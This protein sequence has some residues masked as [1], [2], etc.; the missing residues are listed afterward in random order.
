MALVTA[1][2]ILFEHI[3]ITETFLKKNASLGFSPL[4][5]YS[6]K[7]LIMVYFQGGWE[8]NGEAVA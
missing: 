1:L 3:L 8:S 7:F 6:I 2:V 4:N 5:G